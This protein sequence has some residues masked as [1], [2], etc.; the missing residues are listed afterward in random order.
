MEGYNNK[1]RTERSQF[2]PSGYKIDELKGM[3]P[4]ELERLCESEG[5]DFESVVRLLGVAHHYKREAAEVIEP[6]FHPDQDFIDDVHG[7]FSGGFE[8]GADDLES[9]E[10]NLAYGEECDSKA[11]KLLDIY[12]DSATPI[13]RK[14]ELKKEIYNLFKTSVLQEALRRLDVLLQSGKSYNTALLAVYQDYFVNNKYNTNVP[15]LREVYDRMKWKFL[16]YSA[17]N[18]AEERKAIEGFVAILQKQAN[19]E[20]TDEDKAVVQ[21]VIR[22]VKGVYQRGET[23]IT[24]DEVYLPAIGPLADFYAK[25]RPKNVMSAGSVQG[26]EV[27]EAGVYAD[28]AYSKGHRPRRYGDG[29]GR[30]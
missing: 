16:P 22:A 5:L 24:V 20:A 1:P 19:G 3:E 26:S 8:L 28:N 10:R 6:A 18:T 14:R 12:E 4:D 9:I 30:N 27:Y 11:Y 13:A 7:R 17:G 15:I 29:L 23:T 21:K 25:T 2:L